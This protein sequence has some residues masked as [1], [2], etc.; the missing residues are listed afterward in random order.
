M[1]LDEVRSRW[2]SLNSSDLQ[3]L[4]LGLL[5]DPVRA[6]IAKEATSILKSATKASGQTKGGP[7]RSRPHRGVD[8]VTDVVVG[9]LCPQLVHSPRR[10]SCMVEVGELQMEVGEE[11]L[12]NLAVCN[13]SCMVA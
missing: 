2:D 4:M 5:G 13:L 3:R 12:A 1:A 6:K 11:I 7:I 10:R 8:R 9:A